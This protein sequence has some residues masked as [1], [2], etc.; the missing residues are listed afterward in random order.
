[1]LGAAFAGAGGQ[2]QAAILLCLSAAS[3][4]QSD[5]S[6]RW[7]YERLAVISDHLADDW[8]Q[9]FDG[10]ADRFGEPREP[11]PP[12]SVSWE[13]SVARS[14]LEAGESETMT[15]TELAAFAR[16][17]RVAQDEDPWSR[18]NWRGLGEDAKAQAKARPSEFSMASESFADVNRTVVTGLL[19]GLEDAVREGEAIAWEETLG[20]IGA[21]A[22][23]SEVRDDNADLSVEQDSSWF[24][25]K[26]EALDLLEAGLGSEESPPP[27]LGSLLWETIER[28]AVHGQA[29]D[30]VV[31]D[32][33]RDSV[34]AALNAIRS[35]A[36]Y[37]A[38]VYLWWLGR[39]GTNAVPNEV[40]R[41][42][43]RILDPRA[44]PFIGMRAAVAHRLPQLAYVDADWTARLLPEVFPDRADWPEHWD[45]AWDAY[46]R[47]ATPLPPEPL[48]EAM[49]GYYTHA[50]QLIDPG[51]EVGSEGDPVLHLG[52]HLA[53]MY[54]HGM[55]ELD[56]AN[57]VAFF[58]RAPAAIRP[59]ILDWIGRTAAQDDLPT[60]WFERAQ[61]FFE[62]REQEIAAKG[63]DGT[64]LR[65]L[66]WFVAS[67]A[68]PVQWWGPR[69]PDA[70]K[71]ATN[72]SDAGFVPFD[73]VMSRVAEACEDD[74]AM[75]LQVLEV[76][77][78]QAEWGWH[79]Q[80]LD[81]AQ[82]IITKAA[83]VPDLRFRARQVAD[84]LAR[85][86]HDEFEQFAAD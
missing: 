25:A 34:F 1:M 16:D 22:P 47:H 77:V 20:L 43:R 35:R 68:F 73:D 83:E 74:T 69:L 53:L 8:A 60:G 6:D 63:L 76:V 13:A 79:G 85:D 49:E 29:P 78:S 42:F 11:V 31:L 7:L 27:Q 39:H 54:L 82:M 4:A 36:V 80:Y 44:E 86:G 24:A 15:A 26:S 14:P 3:E 48:L 21:I 67:G 32:G 61:Q 5:D 70:L 40:D 9:R 52:M 66:G 81:A 50:V 30:D 18:P 45:A 71:S 56:H 75:A 33:P 72:R 17:W 38:I 51:H 65:K 58:D 2:E 64:E 19:R 57:L 46:V 10:Y 23:K 37:T 55:I 59:R 28:F 84:R 12:V 41:F 62:W